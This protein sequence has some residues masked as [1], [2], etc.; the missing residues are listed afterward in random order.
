MRGRKGHFTLKLNMSKA[1]DRVEWDF[2]ELMMLKMGFSKHWMDLVLHCVHSVSY[3]VILN[4]EVGRAFSLR[5]GLRQG[6]PLSPYL[7]LI[8]CKGLSSHMQQP[9]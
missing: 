2:L 3:S 9:L 5:Q 1:Y 6:D 4:G 8:C 7:F